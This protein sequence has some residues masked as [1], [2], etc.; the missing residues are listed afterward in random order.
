M[1]QTSETGRG[2]CPILLNGRLLPL[3]THPKADRSLTAHGG[4]SL[5]YV[6]SAPGL[7]S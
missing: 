2:G 6:R 7:M 5:I 3:A 4:R 1:T